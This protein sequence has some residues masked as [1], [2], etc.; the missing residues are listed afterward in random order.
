MRSS[1]VAVFFA[2]ALAAIPLSTAE[3]IEG[4]FPT[5][6]SPQCRD[7]TEAL[8]EASPLLQNASD[9]LFKAADMDFSDDFSSFA[10]FVPQED[11][12]EFTIVCTSV[13]GKVLGI[14]EKE[15][16]ECEMAA[17]GETSVIFTI[18]NTVGCFAQSCNIV[19][20]D[21]ILSLI[22]SV[23]APDLTCQEEDDG[24]GTF[25]S[26]GHHSGRTMGI[27]L[28]SFVAIGVFALLAVFVSR[29][30]RGGGGGRTLRPVDTGD[31]ELAEASVFT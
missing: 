27:A 2:G 13:G 8:L 19:E 4:L 15:T 16:V 1:F 24:T 21:F 9:A 14:T 11:V 10:I 17:L 30:S 23:A 6:G 29:R 25:D 5:M 26:E 18:E 31:L 28:L 3:D 7:D 12:D 20:Q 22:A